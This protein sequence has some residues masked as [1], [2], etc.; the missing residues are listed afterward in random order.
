[1]K[2][3]IISLIVALVLFVGLLKDK[4]HGRCR[5]LCL[6]SERHAHGMSF[7]IYPLFKCIVIREQIVQ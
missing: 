4:I 7:T 6:H 5:G 1:M 2:K 3:K